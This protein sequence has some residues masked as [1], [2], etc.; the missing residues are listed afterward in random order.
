MNLDD[1]NK[2]VNFNRLYNVIKSSYPNRDEKVL[3]T[4]EITSQV[5]FEIEK[6]PAEVVDEFLKDVREYF[7]NFNNN[8]KA[9]QEKIYRSNLDHVN[10]VQNFRDGIASF[11]ENQ[12]KQFFRILWKKY[13]KGIVSPGEAVGAVAA[14]SIGEPG[15]QMTLKTFHFAGVASMNITLGVPRIKEIINSTKVI[16]TPIITAS[17]VEKNDI[18]AA[19]IVKGRIEKTKL[20]EV[21][22]YVKEVMSPQKCQ[23]ELKLDMK[24]IADLNLEIT[25]EQVT[26]AIIA[27]KKLKV[28][29]KNIFI[30]KT[31]HK[32]IIHP[33]DVTRENMYFTLQILKK[34]I[35]DVIVSGISNITRAVINKKENSAAT[36]GYTYNL[37]IEGN[38]LS[39][40]MVTPG[41]NHKQCFSN[42]IIEVEK[43]LGIEAA[44]KT[45][46]DE[47]KF[48]M[49]GHGIYVDIRHLQLIADL[50]TFKGM[51]LGFTRFGLTKMQDST[52]LHSSFEKTV[53][54]LFESSFHSRSDKVRGVS[55][56][57]IMVIISIYNV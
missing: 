48:T 34:K 23:L 53:E 55:E 32:I 28:K 42:N 57:I 18:I 5:E 15:T 14:Q 6:R 36:E 52:L 20:S 46:I 10:A 35:G 3:T 7:S 22:K 16:S 39:D 13:L 49:G 1:G 40:I 44:R 31:K 17:L 33:Y 2:V 26:S 12:I 9:V 27:H 47:I 54:N 19:R 56:C 25:E 21:L 30:D 45:I 51:V 8:I 38:G 11:T 24:T 4:D 37:V 50:M 41:I 29:D 43:V